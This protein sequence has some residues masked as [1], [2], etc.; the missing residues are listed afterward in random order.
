MLRVLLYLIALHSFFTGVGLVLQPEELIHWGGWGD[1]AQPFFAAQGG[2]FHILMAMLYVVAARRDE[3]RTVLV[4]Y[5]VFVKIAAAV[6]LLI[7]FLCVQ[8]I[9]LV[10]V[11]GFADGIM[12]AALLVLYR[13]VNHC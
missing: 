5:I 9:W 2:V 3:A 6:F 7:Y 10:L 12:G 11:S 8:P 13:H 4:P 1:I